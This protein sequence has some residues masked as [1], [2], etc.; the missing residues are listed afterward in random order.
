MERENK[1]IKS[2]NYNYIFFIREYNYIFLSKSY[3][4]YHQKE[5]YEL[6]FIL[7]LMI[8]FK[9]NVELLTVNKK[10]NCSLILL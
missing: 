2:F 5:C 4:L 9:K 7:I 6:F 1:K 10:N 3:E 8:I